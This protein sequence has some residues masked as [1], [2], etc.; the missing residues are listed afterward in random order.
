M[1]RIRKSRAARVLSWLLTVG[2]VAPMI[3]GIVAPTPALAQGVGGG[4]EQSAIIGQFE[5][6]S[7]VQGARLGNFATTAVSN[8]LEGQGRFQFVAARDVARVAEEEGLKAPYDQ[9]ANA[10]IAA[11]VGA[12]N[13]VT[14]EIAF[15]KSDTKGGAKTVRVGLKVRVLEAS[16]GDLLN[17]AAQVGTAVARP[18]QDEYSLI[19]EATR[20]AAVLAAKEV[21]AYTLPEG[22]VLNLVGG[23]GSEV[24]VL[25]N[26]GSRDGIKEGMQMIVFRDKQRVG[27]IQVTATLVSDSEAKI[28]ENNYGFQPE[29]K[30]RAIFPM[31]DF[32][33]AGTL[34]RGTDEHHKTSMSSLGKVMV[35]LLAGVV[36]WAAIG[37]GSKSSVTGVTAEADIQT[38]AP[39]VRIMWRDN[40]FAGNTLEYHVWRN[41]DAP[42]NY[43]G[44]PVAMTTGVGRTYEDYPT[45]YSF[46]DG[47][48]SFLQPATS[49][50]SSSSSTNSGAGNATSV[51]PSTT[52]RTLGFTPGTSY[53]YG[54]NSV[55]RRTYSSN[56]SSS[57]SSSSSTGTG[58]TT[59]D[60]NSDVVNSGQVTPIRAAELGA[61][62]QDLATNVDITQFNPTWMST[63]GADVFVV[64]VST[65]R[66]FTNRNV[67]YQTPIIYSTAPRA[68]GVTQMLASVINLTTNAVLLRDATFKAYVQSGGTKPTLFW[69]VGARNDADRP[70]PVHWISRNH[71]DGDRTFR[72]VYSDIRSFTPADMPPSPPAGG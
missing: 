72:F 29:D 70:G 53:T 41:P 59:E 39:A 14:G 37:G 68:D 2:L 5:N 33:A 71:S 56:S 13:I 10:R 27:K 9:I 24:Q 15:V 34:V 3:R 57:S 43:T 31:P 45:P 63:S 40:L 20:N 47:T 54:I 7:G 19:E 11:K 46:W 1:K 60:I 48:R 12:S 49:S 8:E 66:S 58:T 4:N 65:D 22:I 17:G 42:F 23:H 16:S 28:L 36:I 25:I 69:R 61:T 67:I 18:G 51:T 62:P 50:T 21:M 6:K 64:E 55:I 26:K 52:N 38:G 30:V 35:V 32:S 44:I